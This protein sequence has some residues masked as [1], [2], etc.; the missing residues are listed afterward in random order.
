MLGSSTAGKASPA[1]SVMSPGPGTGTESNVF[2]RESWSLLPADWVTLL[3][4]LLRLPTRE[5]RLGRRI[6]LAVSWDDSR[7]EMGILCLSIYL[8]SSLDPGSCRLC[9]ITRGA[10]QATQYI[11]K[12]GEGQGVG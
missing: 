1:V 10:G 11:P 8:E 6:E 5:A 2:W 4:E 3:E 7:A 9:D 12:V